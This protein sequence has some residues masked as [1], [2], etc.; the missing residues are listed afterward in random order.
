MKPLVLL[1]AIKLLSLVGAILNTVGFLTFFF[2]PSIAQYRWHLIV[3]GIAVIVVA[4]IASRWLVKTS[5]KA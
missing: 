1:L 5:D 4:E 3:G 2:W